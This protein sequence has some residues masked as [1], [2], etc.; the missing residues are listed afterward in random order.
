MVRG[1][2]AG[3]I[4]RGNPARVRRRSDSNS[5]RRKTGIRGHADLR[6]RIHLSIDLDGTASRQADIVCDTVGFVVLNNG[7]ATD[8]HCSGLISIVFRRNIHAAAICRSR[9]IDD[10]TAIYIKLIARTNEH[11]AAVLINNM[12]AADL[13]AVHIDYKCTLIAAGF[14]LSDNS[15]LCI[16]CDLAAIHVE[17]TAA[18]LTNLYFDA[19]ERTAIETE[20]V[21][22]RYC[23]TTI[24]FTGIRFQFPFPIHTTVCQL[25]GAGW[26]NASNIGKRHGI[27]VQAD[28]GALRTGITCQ[29]H[30]SGQ[31]VIAGRRQF[32]RFCPR[33]E[34]NACIVCMP[35]D[36][37]A[38]IA[39][40]AMLM[41]ALLTQH[42]RIAIVT[43]I[44]LKARAII[45]EPIRYKL[46]KIPP[47]CRIRH[48]NA[49]AILQILLPFHRNAE[50]RGRVKRI[51]ANLLIC[52]QQNVLFDTCISSSR[53]ISNFCLAAERKV[54]ALNMHAYRIPTD[55][56]A[57]HGECA[58]I[59]HNACCAACDLSAA[60]LAPIHQRQAAAAA[61]LYR[62]NIAGSCRNCLP[63]QAKE[64]FF[65]NLP[66]AVKRNCAAN[67]VVSV[68]CDVR[69]CRHLRKLHI[70]MHMRWIAFFVLATIIAYPTISLFQAG[71]PICTAAVYA[72]RIYFTTLFIAIIIELHRQ[73]TAIRIRLLHTRNTHGVIR[74][75][76]T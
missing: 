59:E 27:A 40:D 4:L 51:K 25:R 42:N 21:A 39:A 47:A 16:P 9:V 1:V 72:P 3:E 38:A 23:Y 34:G 63:V 24:G 7:I 31:V 50:F 17:R 18:G 35:I 19:I 5:P 49:L 22:T 68:R 52:R 48:G 13:A 64:N 71:I 29:S 60:V 70:A 11:T 58:A 2:I 12:V 28:V 65:I 8:R 57:L 76:A 43:Q 10:L 54:A 55:F 66:C 15:S 20:L 62:R 67:V 26:V 32:I 30:I 46:R 37:L 6:T 14:T 69:Q 75:F 36:I 33:Q 45:L 61:D 56:A 44:K 73:L 41:D 53:I 74:V